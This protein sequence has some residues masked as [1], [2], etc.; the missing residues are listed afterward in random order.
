MYNLLKCVELWFNVVSAQFDK[1][2]HVYQKVWNLS[3]K[4]VFSISQWSRAGLVLDKPVVTCSMSIFICV[5]VI[6]STYEYNCF[7]FV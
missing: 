7:G 4:Y 2:P 3:R 1:I 5:H 6:R